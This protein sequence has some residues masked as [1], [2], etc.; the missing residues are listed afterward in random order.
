[1]LRWA[2]KCLELQPN[3]PEKWSAEDNAAI[4]KGKEETLVE[5]MSECKAGHQRT[6]W[7]S[8]VFQL[9]RVLGILLN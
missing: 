8:Q 1:M 3:C 6:F 7:R 4:K 2:G 5:M 9:P